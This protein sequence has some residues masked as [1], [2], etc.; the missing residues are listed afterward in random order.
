MVVVVVEPALADRDSAARYEFSESR[1]GRASAIELSGVVRVYAGRREHEPRHGA[2]AIVA[3]R[4]AASSDSPMQTI[5][6]APA[7]SARSMTASRSGIER[8]I[9]KVGVTVDECGHG[10]ANRRARR[11]FIER[12]V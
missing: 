9:G 11:R 5:A 7:S 1:P 4:A 8:R 10:Y 3:A 2:G 12:T 6:R